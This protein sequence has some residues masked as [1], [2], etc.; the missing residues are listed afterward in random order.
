YHFKHACRSPS[1]MCVDIVGRSR[2]AAERDGK[3]QN[4]AGGS[5]Q[6]LKDTVM[7][8]ADGALAFVDECLK[9][10]E[11]CRPFEQESAEAFSRG[12]QPRRVIEAPDEWQQLGERDA[13]W[14]ARARTVCSD[15][16]GR[17]GAGSSVTRTPMIGRGT[18]GRWSVAN[19]ARPESSGVIVPAVTGSVG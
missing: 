4:A 10:R 5:D 16:V 11:I 17:P 9:A 18:S 13:H 6:I 8:F 7:L 19:V 15:G 12:I 3:L 2:V 14:A 1:S